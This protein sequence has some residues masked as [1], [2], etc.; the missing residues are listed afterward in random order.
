M[1]CYAV[2]F[3]G[4]PNKEYY[5]A[6][7]MELP[8]G[9]VCEIIAD[10]TTTYNNYVTIKRKLDYVESVAV[11]LR[12]LRTITDYKIINRGKR[13]DDMIQRVFF[14]KKKR[15]TCVL[16]K[17]G[18]KTIVK[19]AP[20]DGWDEEKALA[21]CYMKRMLGNRSSFNETLKKYCEM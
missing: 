5:Y 4:T 18:V 14:N 6:S 9:A 1:N 16:W 21:L 12:G 10:G 11:S 19:C 8:I 7:S 15:T 17:D 20:E 13:P 2:I 3:N